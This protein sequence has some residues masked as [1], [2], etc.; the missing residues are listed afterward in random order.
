[1]RRKIIGFGI[2]FLWVLGRAV[3]SYSAGDADLQELSISAQKNA[4]IAYGDEASWYE[5]GEVKFAISIFDEEWKELD[6]KEEMLAVCQLPD[7]LLKKLSTYELLKLTE[8]Y[9]MLGDIYAA[10]T[11]KEGFRNLVDSFNGLRELL[12]REDCLE[13]VCGEYKNLTFPEKCAISYSECETEEEKVALFN[14]ILHND[15]LLKIEVEDSKPVLVCDLL[16]MIMLDKTTEEN[17]EMLLEIVVDKAPEKEKSEYF[18]ESDKN[19]YVSEL[20]ESM[21]SEASAYAVT[22]ED[23]N[24]TVKTVYWKGI[25]IE[26]KAADKIVYNDYH[27]I[28]EMLSGRSDG[29]KLSLVNVG[30]QQS[31]CHSYAWLSR[32][33]PNKYQ[34]YWLN[35]V[36]SELINDCIKSNEPK[37]GYIAYKAQHSAIVVDATHRNEIYQYD[38]IVIG[39]WAGGAII[40]GPMSAGAFYMEHG[41]GGVVNY[42]YYN[43]SIK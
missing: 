16:E 18:E 19:L 43:T 13:V 3:K 2:I 17:V 37:N 29:D 31:N 20:E 38:P 34:Y 15:E 30:T 33:F 27:D 36:P 24:I 42:Y 28:M 11:T 21:L 7:K 35:S 22:E 8:E 25:A 5:N 26:V 41:A 14:E 40:K 6:G 23:V 39:K 12:S 10:D 32:L 1:M 4:D 9:P